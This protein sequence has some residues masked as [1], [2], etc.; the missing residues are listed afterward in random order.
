MYAW[1]QILEGIAFCHHM[2]IVHRDLKP[3]NLLID[4]VIDNGPFLM[5]ARF[6]VHAAYYQWL[7]DRDQFESHQEK[8]RAGNRETYVKL[9]FRRA[10]PDVRQFGADA[11]GVF[12]QDSGPI[13]PALQKK[14]EK[15][16][17]AYAASYCSAPSG[18][19]VQ[20]CREAV[21]KVTI[22]G[23][24]LTRMKNDPK[25]TVR[26]AYAAELVHRDSKDYQGPW[27]PGELSTFNKVATEKGPNERKRECRLIFFFYVHYSLGLEFY[28]L[29]LVFNKMFFIKF[30][31][32][33][34][35]PF[36]S[37]EGVKII[38]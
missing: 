23:A 10:F 30:H 28:G 22:A 26:D 21:E 13:E 36:R 20:S 31:Y 33:S 18:P 35:G 9:Q 8:I 24:L 16:A 38:K 3:E 32:F 27:M 29:V 37:H 4:N 12:L 5:R 17:R 11:L 7:M 15:A 1:F 19:S 34:N 14:I 25:M 6:L 2:H